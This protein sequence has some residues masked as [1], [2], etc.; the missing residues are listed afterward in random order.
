MTTAGTGSD[1]PAAR[2]SVIGTFVPSRLAVQTTC[3]SM[4]SP[5]VFSG[6]NTTCVVRVSRSWRSTVLGDDGDVIEKYTVRSSGDTPTSS[7]TLADTYRQSPGR[8]SSY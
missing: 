3:A 5:G 6:R 4:F 2:T 1:L 8:S 7:P